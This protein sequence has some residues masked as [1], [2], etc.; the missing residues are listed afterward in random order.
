L[1]DFWDLPG[2]SE[3]EGTEKVE[4]ESTVPGVRL[5]GYKPQIADLQTSI[6][7]TCWT[8]GLEN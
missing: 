2:A 8:A 6:S 4:G 5:T 3:I 7:K 1:N